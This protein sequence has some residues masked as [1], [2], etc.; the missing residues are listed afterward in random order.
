MFTRR[1]N[2]VRQL[3]PNA[4][5]EILSSAGM[6]AKLAPHFRG[7]RD[8]ISGLPYYWRQRL[9]E[10]IALEVVRTQQ[11]QFASQYPTR[12]G[13]MLVDV[14]DTFCKKMAEQLYVPGAEEM[15]EKF[16]PWFARNCLGF[17]H[18]WATIDS[19]VLHQVFHKYRYTNLSTSE[20]PPEMQLLPI[21][22]APYSDYFA[23]PIVRA[24]QD[25]LA[26]QGSA[27]LMIWNTHSLLGEH[28]HALTT[29]IFEI[30]ALRDLILQD[31]SV[32]QPKGL[33]FNTEAYGVGSDEVT[34]VTIN[35]NDGRGPQKETIGQS[36]QNLLEAV[37]QVDRLFIVGV[38]GDFCVK[39]SILQIHKATIAK[40]P[41]AARK[42]FIVSD[43]TAFI[44]PDGKIPGVGKIF[45]TEQEVYAK[46]AAMGMNVVSMAEAERLIQS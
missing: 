43:G 3:P 16:A 11:P 21:G 8:L 9:V 31:Q 27:P 45:D 25:Q 41:T 32:M 40:D 34:E 19:H 1:S 38:A 14:Q 36:N 5:S 6:H 33:S 24:Y 7:I 39:S 37:Q 26:R 12:N 46:Y 22:L 44:Y 42:I 15:L 13:I 2:L 20:W 30:M 17:S 23:E 28:G 4:V 35:W 10:K 18:A 29:L